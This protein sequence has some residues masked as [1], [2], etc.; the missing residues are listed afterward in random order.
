MT[1]S[2]GEGDGRGIGGGEADERRR[3]LPDNQYP[4]LSV[5]VSV[6]AGLAA[7]ISSG[8]V[9]QPGERQRPA[10]ASNLYHAAHCGRQSWAPVVAVV[11]V[12]VKGD[13]GNKEGGLA[14][15]CCVRALRSPL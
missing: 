13:V 6:F 15:S 12:N 10:L 3:R 11:V 14:S 5:S 2:T 7:A 8:V 9:S 4:I 1:P